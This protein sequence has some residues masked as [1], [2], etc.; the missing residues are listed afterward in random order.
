MMSYEDFQIALREFKAQNQ[1]QSGLAKQAVAC[2]RGE[3]KTNAITL[4][5]LT[6]MDGKYV[7]LV[8]NI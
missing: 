3:P 6:L 4:T 8:E 5:P 2:V 1:V 7:L